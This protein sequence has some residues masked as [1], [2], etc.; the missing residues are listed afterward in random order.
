MN[1]EE[2][3]VSAKAGDESTP[4]TTDTTVRTPAQNTTAQTSPALTPAP[5]ALYL[6]EGFTETEA[7]MLTQQTGNPVVDLVQGKVPLGNLST[8]VVVSFSSLALAALA[9]AGCIIMAAQAI[10]RRI[11]RQGNKPVSVSALMAVALGAAT[12]AGWFVL[13]SLAKPT[14]W[15]NGYTP[16][17]AVL[18]ALFAAAVVVH[19]ALGRRAA[20]GRAGALRSFV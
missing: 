8:T 18:F 7:E 9:A 13:D 4:S 2:P 10:R 17:V 14:A 12:I 19:V 6:E 1:T 15:V 5:S 3:E 20:R 11:S 16:A